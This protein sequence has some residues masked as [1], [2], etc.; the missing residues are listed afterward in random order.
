MNYLQY[1]K[2]LEICIILFDRLGC[3]VYMETSAKY[4]KG[5]KN[6]IVVNEWMNEWMK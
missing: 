5:I 2:A 1:F 4:D 3:A 6:G